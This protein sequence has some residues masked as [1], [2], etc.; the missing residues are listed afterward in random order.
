MANG[1]TK[2][3]LWVQ[4]QMHAQDRHTCLQTDISNAFG[5][6][7]RQQV[8][9]GFHEISQ[10]LADL[11]GAWVA[12][13]TPALIDTGLGEGRVVYTHRGLPQGDP[14]STYVFC[15]GMKLVQRQFEAEAPPTAKWA[16]YIDDTVL[17]CANEDLDRTWEA[18]RN[19]T[20]QAG[21]QVNDAKTKLW[22]PQGQIPPHYA[23][24]VT[25]HHLGQ[26][27]TFAIS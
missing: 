20:T 24:T 16:G 14:F 3:G 7:H 21:L 26:M 9:A 27:T 1:V 22:S 23:S 5:G 2:F 12:Q 8:L 11:V 6:L 15:V 10:D 25:L 13:P 17:I 18:F 4:Q 19:A